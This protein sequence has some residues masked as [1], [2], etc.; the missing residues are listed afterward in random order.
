MDQQEAEEENRGRKNGSATP[1]PEQPPP[2]E[3]CCS[4]SETRPART[5]WK[6]E[7]WMIREEA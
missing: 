4:F 1:F 7:L 6:R 5:T 2:K 3:I